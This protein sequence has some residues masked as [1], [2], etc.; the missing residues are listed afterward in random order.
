MGRILGRD[1]TAVTVNDATG[2]PL[3]TLTDTLAINF[4]VAAEKKDNTNF[5]VNWKAMLAGLLG[6]DDFTH[7]LFYDNVAAGFWVKMAARLS[8]VPQVPQTF[9]FSDALRTVTMTTLVTKITAPIQV[10]EIRKFTVTHTMT[11]VVTFS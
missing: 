8:Q 7:E 3:A 10:A 11:G 2:S 9:V 6:G 1:M 5:G 4:D